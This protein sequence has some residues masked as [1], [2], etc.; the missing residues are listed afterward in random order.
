MMDRKTQKNIL[1]IGMGVVSAGTLAGL[2][3]FDLPG[4]FTTKIGD[5]FNL[6][7]VGAAVTGFGIYQIYNNWF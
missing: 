3:G 1:L 5:M 2:F 7:H 6:L 4:F